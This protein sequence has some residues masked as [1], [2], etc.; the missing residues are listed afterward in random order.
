MARRLPPTSRE[1]LYEEVWSEPIIAVAPRYGLSD[2]GLL[3]VCRKLHIPVPGRGYWAKVKAGQTP[4][5]IALP[6]VAPNVRLPSGPS[7]LTEQEAAARLH[8]RSAATKAHAELSAFVVPAE[9]IDMHPLIRAAATRLKRRDGWT[10]V[11]GIRSAPKEVLNIQ[12]SREQLERS[13]LLMNTLL[14]GLANLG[15]IATIDPSKELTRLE[16]G[17]TLQTIS[18]I[19]RVSRTDHAQTLAEKRA[20]ERYAS[21]LRVGVFIPYPS[22]PI[23]DYRATGMLTLMVGRRQWNDTDR[24]TLESRLPSIASMIIGMAAEQC[25][26]EA[27]E[28]RRAREYEA[29]VHDYNAYVEVM[30]RERKSLQ[31][32]LRDARRWQRANVLREYLGAVEAHAA[33]APGAMPER[34]ALVEWGRAKADWMDPLIARHDPILDAPAPKRPSRWDF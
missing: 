5:R 31:A 8:R 10:Q 26:R 6:P 32:L 2:V 30:N 23:H 15:F 18:L 13:L 29:A 9:L 20:L 3:K 34:A 24:S 22:V 4:R 14:K 28:A 27:D 7:P 21:S 16:G 17:G 19:E 12:V 33:G 25:A 1:A 11:A